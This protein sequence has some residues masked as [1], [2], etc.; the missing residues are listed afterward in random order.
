MRMLYASELGTS[1]RKSWHFV[2]SVRAYRI[3]IPQIFVPDSLCK[4]IQAVAEKLDFV[5]QET[6]TVK[7]EIVQ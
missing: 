5:K 7:I 6:P 4:I 2:L 3:E 1:C